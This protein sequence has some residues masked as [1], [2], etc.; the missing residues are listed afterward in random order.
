MAQNT[1]LGQFNF[2][3]GV[4]EYNKGSNP[5]KHHMLRYMLCTRSEQ[6]A[7]HEIRHYPLDSLIIRSLDAVDE[8]SAQ[9]QLNDIFTN[10][11]NTLNTEDITT[12]AASMKGRIRNTLYRYNLRASIVD[13]YEQLVDILKKVDIHYY[14]C[15][16]VFDSRYDISKYNTDTY[17]NMKTKPIVH[18]NKNNILEP[19]N[20]AFVD[21]STSPAIAIPV[22][23]D[24]EN[25]V[26]LYLNF[27]EEIGMSTVVVQTLLQTN[28]DH[29]V[30]VPIFTVQT[31]KKKIKL[32][33]LDQPLQRC[34]LYTKAADGKKNTSIKDPSL[35]RCFSSLTGDGKR[36]IIPGAFGFVRIPISVDNDTVRDT[37]LADYRIK[38]DITSQGYTL[39]Q[40]AP[41]SHTPVT[42]AIQLEEDVQLT[43]QEAVQAATTHH[44]QNTVG[45]ALQCI[46]Q[47]HQGDVI[48]H[49]GQ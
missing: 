2:L 15:K 14:T 8:T 28:N 29:V 42:P 12:S 26:D 18:Y 20:L 45:T 9:N 39:M 38:F 21:E 22:F 1:P 19:I 5:K 35:R 47:G 3:G 31:E 11:L 17:N 48:L 37:L 7:P 4:T 13:T 30:D 41:L 27:L 6:G 49:E 16:V 43:A 33:A 44:Y 10:G 25:A 32:F 36:N 23:C 40:Y 46:K 24:N 34:N